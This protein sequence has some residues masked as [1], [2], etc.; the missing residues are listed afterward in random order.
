MGSDEVAVVSWLDGWRSSIALIDICS[1]VSLFE[2]AGLASP[3]VSE[4]I[5]CH[6]LIS[7]SGQ[8]G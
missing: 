5:F 2:T 8:K 6:G 7:R 4:A 1:G 3:T